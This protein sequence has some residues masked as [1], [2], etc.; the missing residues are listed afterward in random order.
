LTCASPEYLERHGVPQHPADLAN[1]QGILFNNRSFFWRF[2]VNGE[3]MEAVPRGRIE[4]NSAA[5]CVTAA[6]SGAGIA[7]LF[8]YQV[9]EEL[10]S[11]ALVPILKGYGSEPRPIHIVYSRQGPLALKVRAFIDCAVPLLRASCSSYGVKDPLGPP[12]V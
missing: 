10:S 3:R 12:D 11:G 8:D 1:H 2:D 5:N 4:L 6:L 7:R 9:S